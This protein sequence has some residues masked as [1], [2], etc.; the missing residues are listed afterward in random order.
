M[1]EN[2]S[3]D[4]HQEISAGLF[5]GWPLGAPDAEGR[6]AFARGGDA[7]Q[8]ALWNLLLTTPGERFMRP[9]FGAGLRQWI[10]Q[11][12]TE[13]TRALIASS[14]TAAIAKWEQRAAVSGVTVT[15]APDDPASVIVAV[16]YTQAGAV[17]DAPQTLT[18]SLALGS[19]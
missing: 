16:S 6:L 10:G 18:L 14:V 9:G 12:N 3:S 11:P 1:G 15:T 13:T 5:V 7:L 17:A 19:V 8:E 4:S 2:M